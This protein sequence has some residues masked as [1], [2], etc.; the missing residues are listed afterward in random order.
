[1]KITMKIVDCLKAVL[2]KFNKTV[3]NKVFVF[4]KY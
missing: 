3:K 4:K 1:M 2:Q